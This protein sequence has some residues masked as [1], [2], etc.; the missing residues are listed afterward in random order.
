MPD[1]KQILEALIFVSETALSRSKILEAL[2]EYPKEE[3]DAALTQLRLEYDNSSRSFALHEV[4]GGFQFRTSPDYK[5]WI[6][7]LKKIAPVRLS[8]E[9]LQT[10]AIIAYKQP[11]LRSEI[12]RIRGVDVSAVLKTL[13]EKKLIRIMGRNKELAGKPLI[14]GTTQKFLE[15]FDLKDLSSLPS[16]KEI[17]ALDQSQVQ[18][19][20]ETI[21]LFDKS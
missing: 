17:K 6:L 8:Q 3:I 2:P 15:V 18:G 13:L 12:E 20:P 4:A 16:L 11:I 1:L 21:N 14:Y 5:D 10:L 19:K 9:A 7:R